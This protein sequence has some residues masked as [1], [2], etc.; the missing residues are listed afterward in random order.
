MLVLG[1]KKN[2]HFYGRVSTRLT[3]LQKVDYLRDGITAKIVLQRSDV[4][5][6]SHAFTITVLIRHP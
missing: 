1:P 6:A 4:M 2:E 5:Q 3:S